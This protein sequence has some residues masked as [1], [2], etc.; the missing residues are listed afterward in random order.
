MEKIQL[1]SR[2]EKNL[3]FIC[4]GNLDNMFCSDLLDRFQSRV[5]VDYLLFLTL[6]HPRRFVGSIQIH[7]YASSLERQS[8]RLY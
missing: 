7:P 6:T 2:K 1:S 8:G 5:S 3:I 4:E